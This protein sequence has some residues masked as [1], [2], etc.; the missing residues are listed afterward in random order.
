MEDYYEFE[1]PGCCLIC[2]DAEPGCLCYDCKCSKCCWYSGNDYGVEEFTPEGDRY[3]VL[4]DVM[5]DQH[6]SGKLSSEFK[7]YERLNYTEKA[8]KCTI[9]NNKSKTISENEFW[10]PLSV[11]N[12]DNQIQSWFIDNK[13]I[14]NF[15]KGLT[16]Q[17]KLM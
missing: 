3:C 7:I 17:R 2:E 8:V 1:D 5:R 12:K 16:S 15:K 4:V 6:E 11:I 13:F 10:V 9:I 14:K